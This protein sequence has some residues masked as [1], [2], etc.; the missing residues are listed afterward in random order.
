MDSNKI[1]NHLRQLDRKGRGFNNESLSLLM[2]AAFALF[3]LVFVLRS[4]AN[5]S[6]DKKENVV[7]SKYSKKKG[8]NTDEVYEPRKLDDNEGKILKEN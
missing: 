3:G 7:F 8:T 4:S 2:L 1:D 6:D 5:S